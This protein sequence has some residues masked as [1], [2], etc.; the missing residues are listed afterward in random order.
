MP[1]RPDGGWRDA[2]WDYCRSYW[3]RELP[4]YEVVEGDHLEGPFNRS[5]G[6]NRA[7]EL[8]GDW[9]VG[10]VL[11]SDVI[12]P[13][14]NVVQA[15]RVAEISGRAV[16]PFSSRDSITMGGT[17]LLL[18]GTVRLPAPGLVH[19]KQPWNVSTCV[20][21]PRRL[22]DQVG[23]FDERFEGWG[24]EDDAFHAACQTLSGV[25]RLGGIAWHLWHQRSPWR[26]NNSMYRMSV[27][28]SDRY[29]AVAGID[30][31]E[32][33]SPRMG[34]VP[35]M[36]ALLAEGRGPNE[37]LAVCL[38]NG[39]RPEEL[40]RTLASFQD[41]AEYDFARR[42]LIVDGSRKVSAPA[43]WSVTRIKGGSYHKAMLEAQRRAIGSGQPWIF[44]VEDDWEFNRTVPIA[45]MKGALEMH[46]D[47]VQMSLLRQAWYRPE[48]EAGGVYRSS[49]GAFKQKDGWVSHRLYWTQNPM[50]TRRSTFAEHW[51]PSRENSERRWGNMILSDKGRVAG[52]WG[53]LDDD[54]W[55][56]HLGAR[57]AG[58]GY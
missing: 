38:T 2:L 1:R 12:L 40:A 49:P 13:A 17:K 36:R 44:W 30:R 37:M 55:V 15:V 21:V 7:A 25:D 5:A 16:L 19:E 43:G 28:L 27:S 18:K 35:A 52:V 8:A 33:Q 34:N 41:K 53:S 58:G 4:D 46:P 20:V 23:G 45:Q 22:W 9:D 56:T 32:P 57:R 14:D 11:D 42:L 51:W 54:P 47:C 3:E 48:I 39:K 29:C 50:L 6:I 26:S 31:K 10:I 24:G